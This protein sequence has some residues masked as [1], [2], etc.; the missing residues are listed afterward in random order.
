M[1]YDVVLYYSEITLSTYVTENV[2]IKM[3][4]RVFILEKH[5][6]PESVVT[7]RALFNSWLLRDYGFGL[8]D[9]LHMFKFVADHA[10]AKP[11]NLG[12]SSSSSRVPFCE[13][14]YGCIV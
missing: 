8:D 12:A 4:S 11:C 14:W 13:K 6:G 9:I 2:N 10:S 5:D 1:L 7:L 3:R